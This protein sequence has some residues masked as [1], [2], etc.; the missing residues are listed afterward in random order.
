MCDSP[1][2]KL[3]VRYTRYPSVKALRRAWESTRTGLGVP[4]DSGSCASKLPAEHGWFYTSDKKKRVQGRWMCYRL[5]PGDV[6]VD[7]TYE[8]SRM[9]IQLFNGSLSNQLKLYHRGALDPIGPS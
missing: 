2:S 6:D 4:K 5:A 1:I 7:W 8:K 9:L 3:L